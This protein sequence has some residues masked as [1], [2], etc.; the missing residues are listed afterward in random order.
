MI[1]S[2]FRLKLSMI[3][4]H[5]YMLMLVVCIIKPYGHHLPRQPNLEESAISL[6]LDTC[7]WGCYYRWQ[8][9][10]S[11]YW[12]VVCRSLWILCGAG[13]GSC[14]TK[15]VAG[16]TSTCC[17]PLWLGSGAGTLVTTDHIDWLSTTSLSHSD[18]VQHMRAFLL[19][20]R[21]P[22]DQQQQWSSALCSS[23]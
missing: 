19:T 18:S 7:W 14:A 6:Y 13:G 15:T 4:K 21:L 12:F 16:S 20:A 9:K 8:L 2:G 5:I 1:L 22:G 17:S 10:P 3:I 23:L 11:V